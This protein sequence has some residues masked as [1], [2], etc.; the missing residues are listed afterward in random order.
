MQAYASGQT[1]TA[2]AAYPLPATEPSSSL[3]ILDD[4]S[5]RDRPSPPA[6]R[7]LSEFSVDV[8]GQPVR[9]LT[10]GTGRTLLLCHGFLSSAEEFGG[11]FEALAS[12][13]RLI[14]PDL[15]GNGGSP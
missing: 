13:R 5:S 9:C 15:P 7:F 6:E 11:R 12:H 3:H 14:I 8:G 4:S 10:A 1:G 2:V